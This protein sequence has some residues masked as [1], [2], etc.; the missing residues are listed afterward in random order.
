MKRKEDDVK[1]KEGFIEEP[2]DCGEI[3]K[4]FVRFEMFRGYV[5]DIASD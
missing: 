4:G 1:R 2:F 3:T 5:S